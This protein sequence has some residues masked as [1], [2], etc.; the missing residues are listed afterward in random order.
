MIALQRQFSLYCFQSVCVYKWKFFIIFEHFCTFNSALSYAL[1]FVVQK[2]IE[3]ELR[4]WIEIKN[5]IFISASLR[6]LKIKIKNSRHCPSVHFDNQ[7]FRSNLPT[8]LISSKAL[9]ALFNSSF[10]VSKSFTRAYFR[11]SFRTCEPYEDS[12]DMIK[13]LLRSQ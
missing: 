6:F 7:S 10:I 4:H 1:M 12:V 13:L 11:W 2:D 8:Y 9:R 3:L 5:W